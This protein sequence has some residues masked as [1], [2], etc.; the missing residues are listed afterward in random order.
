[1]FTLLCVLVGFLIVVDFPVIFSSSKDDTPKYM[2][3]PRRA[4]SQLSLLAQQ[5]CYLG[6]PLWRAD[7]AALVSMS[8]SF[9]RYGTGGEPRPGKFNFGVGTGG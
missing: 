5:L 8:S 3:D 1:M 4:F 7:Q 6:T 2:P 9:S